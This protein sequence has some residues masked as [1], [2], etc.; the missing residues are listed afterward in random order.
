[1]AIFE[2]FKAEEAAKALPMIVA[3]TVRFLI[4]GS[5]GS[6]TLEA[7]YADRAKEV[8]NRAGFAGGSSS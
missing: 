6:G 2:H 8:L 5:G 3:W 1:L 4:C 7:A